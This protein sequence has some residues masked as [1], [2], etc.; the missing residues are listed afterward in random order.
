MTTPTHTPPRPAR[1]QL[2]ASLEEYFRKVVRLKLG[3]KVIKIA[4]T[5]RGL[6]DRLVLLPA[7]R[8]AY[9]E[10]KT[11]T[12]RLSPAQEHIHEVFA[13]LGHKVETLYG[14]GEIDAWVLRQ[15]PT[16]KDVD[17]WAKTQ[18]RAPR[19]KRPAARS[20][21]TDTSTKN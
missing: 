18:P 3:G 14:R 21:L 12:G 19:Y 2:E 5:E 16:Q 9:I 4:P 8:V 1:A 13:A 6:P 10:L 15:F 20:A 7:G 17:R 11:V